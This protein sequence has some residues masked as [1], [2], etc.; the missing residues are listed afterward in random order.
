MRATPIKTDLAATVFDTQRFCLHDGPGVRTVLFLKGCSLRCQWCCN[1]ESQTPAAE[2]LFDASQ[3]ISC[4]KCV[5]VCPH[6]AIIPP[7]AEDR[8][9]RSRCRGASY[10]VAV[11]P[12]GALRI[13][14]TTMT[15]VNA[16]ATVLRD[17]PYFDV[18]GGGVTLSGGEPLLQAEFAAALFGALK[19]RGVHTALETAGDVPWSAF[20]RV[21]DATDLYLFDIKHADEAAHKTGTGRGNLRIIDNLRRLSHG[22]AT[23]ILRYVLLPGYNM[24]DDS[25]EELVRVALSVD[26][27]EVQLLPFHRLGAGKYT[28]LGRSAPWADVPPPDAEDVRRTQRRLAVELDCPVRSI[29]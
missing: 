21:D 5:D 25:I 13:A 18:S 20:E 14:G 28:Q 26:L 4:G 6:G 19:R 1:P 3:C 29:W 23:I 7:P 8:V 24:D 2:V 27:L 11:C 12:T 9:E 16:V 15:L 22:G 10:C 17:K